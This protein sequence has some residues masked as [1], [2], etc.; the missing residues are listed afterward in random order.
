ML[1]PFFPAL[2]KMN[3]EGDP[4]PSK[5]ADMFKNIEY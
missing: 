1:R 2:E 3:I 5:L 4:R